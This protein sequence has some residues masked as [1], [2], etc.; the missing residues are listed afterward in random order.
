MNQISLPNEIRPEEVA[1]KQTLGAAIELCAELGGFALDKSLQAELGVDKAQF[2]RWQSGQ[3]GIV[4]PKFE[5]L[6]D[7]CGNDAPLFWML[8][9]RG[10]DLHSIRKMESETEKENRELKEQNAALMA[11]LRGGANK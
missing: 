2:S 1:R 8:H 10:Y 4:W 9:Q 3:E 7:A 11:L 6:M 5:K